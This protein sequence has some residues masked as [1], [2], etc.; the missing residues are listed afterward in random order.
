VEFVVDKVAWSRFFPSTSVSLPIF[1]PP[2]AP[3][4]PSSITWGWYNRPVVAAVPSGLSLTTLR[5]ITNNNGRN[6][7]S[8]SLGHKQQQVPSQSVQAPNANSSSLNDI[9]TAD[10]TTFQHVMTELN[11]AESEADRM[12]A[13]TKI[14]LKTR[15]EKWPLKFIGEKI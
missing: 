8:P 9:F 10:A 5:I 7:D 14:A 11:G 1:I 3:Q 13:A 6:E 2:I 15:E 4:S 12:M